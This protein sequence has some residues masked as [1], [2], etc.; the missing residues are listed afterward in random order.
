[1][2]FKQKTRPAWR[3][4]WRRGRDRPGEAA[5]AHQ[6]FHVPQADQRVGTSCGK[7]LPRGVEL[8]A[9]AVG[10]VG[11]D[12]LDGLQLRV[13]GGNNTYTSYTG[14]NTVGYL[15]I[16]FIHQEGTSLGFY[17]AACLDKNLNQ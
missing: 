6:L 8:D 16:G 15:H 14:V 9:D 17:V 7:V 5:N 1:M 11:V 12:G 2:K 4:S 3:E 10:R 13:A